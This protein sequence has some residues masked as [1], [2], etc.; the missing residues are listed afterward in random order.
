MSD[1]NRLFETH[2]VLVPQCAIAVY[3]QGALVD[4]SSQI[5]E[6][7]HAMGLVCGYLD[8]NIAA[9]LQQPR[10]WFDKMASI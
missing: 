7:S 6:A 10:I 2:W 9:V 1:A 3:L 4:V 5:L 8:G